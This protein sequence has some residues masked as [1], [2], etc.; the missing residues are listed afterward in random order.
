[1]NVNQNI[2]NNTYQ[3]IQNIA[4]LHLKKESSASACG[5][6]ILIGEHAVLYGAKAIAMPLPELRMKMSIVP[7]LQ[8]SGGISLKLAGNEVDSQIKA[9][10]GDALKLLNIVTDRV[11]IEGASSL[12]IG[13]GLGSSA[14]LCIAILRLLNNSWGIGAT[15]NE[16][17]I[18]ANELEKRFHGNPSGLDASVVAFEKFISFRKGE[19]IKPLQ[20][21]NESDSW[22]FAIVDSGLRASTNIMIKKAKPWFTN[23]TFGEQ[24]INHFDD[25][26]IHAQKYLSN[27]NHHD[28]ADI[29]TETNK[30]LFE[31][32]I[33]P[34][35]LDE[36]ITVIKKLGI[37]AAKITGAGG[38]GSILCLLTA[39]AHDQQMNLLQQNFGKE[40]VFHAN[41]K[42]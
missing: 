29:I 8:S 16:L 4:P 28:L 37:P 12:P 7:D 42:I 41:P 33:I 40:K 2:E 1:M 5:K 10:V 22:H 25:L 26:A 15:P 21:L 30:L 17:A 14:T 18:M 24:R 27:Q 13:A 3:H 38:G 36:I 39:N 34:A 35:K 19:T 6:A 31:S 11:S 23:K 20:S 32:G 9:V